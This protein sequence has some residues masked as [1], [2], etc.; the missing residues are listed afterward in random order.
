MMKKA[1]TLLLVVF[2]LFFIGALVLSI[3]ILW[4]SESNVSSARQAY[5]TA[6]YLAQAG[7]ER[8]KIEILRGCW[9]GG[10]CWVPGPASTDWET[11][12]SSGNPN[13]TWRFQA[14]IES[15]C[16]NSCRNLTAIG[17]VLDANSSVIAQ[18]KIYCQIDGIRDNQPGG[19]DG[20]DDDLTGSLA[21]YSWHE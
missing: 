9:S 1:Q 8:A 15:N 4:Q 12:I 18:R 20:I 7:M 14:K 19:G 10:D 21:A 17:E 11:N 2:L 3:N 6:L 16:G 13:Y 5:L